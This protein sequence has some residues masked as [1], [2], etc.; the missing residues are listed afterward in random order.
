[1]SHYVMPRKEECVFFPSISCLRRQSEE[2]SPVWLES[3]CRQVRL[4]EMLVGRLGFSLTS[5]RLAL[6]AARAA[7]PGVPG[8]RLGQLPLSVLLWPHRLLWS[9]LRRQVQ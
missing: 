4:H 6:P 5:K 1:M 8:A 7:Q 3:P 9:P 2:A